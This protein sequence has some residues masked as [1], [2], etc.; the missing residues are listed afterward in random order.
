MVPLVTA[1]ES[2]QL[3]QLAEQSG[4]PSLVLMENAALRLAEVVQQ[5]FELDP[6][7][8]IVV[9]CGKGNNG[10][11]GL[12]LARHLH[13][14]GFQVRVFL[15]AAPND[16]KGDAAV[17]YRAAV[18][19]GVPVQPVTTATELTRLAEPLCRA[20]LVVDALLGTGITGEVRGLYADAIPLINE[21]APRVLAVD[22]PSGI[23]SDTGEV[24]GVAVAA[25]A[26][27]AMGAVKLGLVLFP[28]AEH[29]GDLFVGS[30]G[31]P[32]TLLSRLG[33]RRFVT[34]H[35]LVTRAMP[36]RHPNTHKGDYGRV[37]VIGGAPGMTGAALMAGKAALRAGAGLVQVALPKSLNLA[38]ETA[39]LEVMSLP[40]PETESGTIAPDALAALAPRLAWAD[41]I[42]VGCGIARHEQTQTFVRQLIAQT[43]K[44]LVIDADGLVALA[45]QTALL[46]R[47]NGVTV[48]TP[49]PGEMAALLQTTTETVQRDRVGI[50]VH[51]ARECNAIVVLKGART[52]TAAPDGTLFVNPTGNAG[53]AT[54]GC[55]DVLTGIIAAF[56]A[57]RLRRPVPISLAETVAA[58]VFVHGLAG[59]IASW[60]KGETALIAGDL[61]HH[62]PR[63]LLEP[64]LA[65]PL[66]LRPLSPFTQFVLRYRR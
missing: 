60:D 66:T 21:H 6:P 50:A 1:A 8:R 15:L 14:I 39:T 16:L 62:L 17:N 32:P 38:A 10:G 22:I 59:D 26:T 28:G 20:D 43:D 13:N 65:Q 24:C 31:V 61:L 41:V 46:R 19:F 35:A 63:A 40:L 7:K 25:H 37:L 51:A 3:D 11:D 9:V 34:T 56:L 36:P 44:P 18:Q 4:L 27:V 53:M 42:A 47:R 57:Q 64:E 23:N 49:H 5:H 12:A 55:G 2:R 54:G 48:L 45:G 58:A 52:I 30:L 29:A 33:V